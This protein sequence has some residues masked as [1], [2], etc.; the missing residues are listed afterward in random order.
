M[1]SEYILFGIFILVVALTL[2]L[3]GKRKIKHKPMTPQEL[4]S[5]EV[6]LNEVEVYVSY[7]LKS[8]A[9]ELLKQGKNIYPNNQKIRRKLSELVR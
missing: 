7:D 5:P 8:N 6:L 1:G 2:I 3:F 4:G 9:I